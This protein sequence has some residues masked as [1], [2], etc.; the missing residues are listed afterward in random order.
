[1]HP[2][3]PTCVADLVRAVAPVPQGLQVEFIRA[4]SYGAGT[5]SSG[6]VSLKTPVQADVVKDR[7]VLVVRPSS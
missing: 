7:H 1:M 6:E 4:S 5:E 2:A 3:M